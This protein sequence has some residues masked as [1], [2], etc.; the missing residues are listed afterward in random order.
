[1]SSAVSFPPTYVTRYADILLV[2]SNFQKLY[3][4]GRW[5]LLPETSIIEEYH[6]RRN[7]REFPNIAVCTI[8]CFLP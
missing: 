1:M 4:S 8:W 7:G 2:S 5:L 3:D 6:K